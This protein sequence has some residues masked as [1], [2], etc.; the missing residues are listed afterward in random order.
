[1]P[2]R[3]LIGAAWALRDRVRITDAFYVACAKTLDAELVTRDGA[4][5]R[6][7]LPDIA[8]RYVT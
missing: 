8:I 7:P 5:S 2:Q 4:L 6:A 3:D 1:M